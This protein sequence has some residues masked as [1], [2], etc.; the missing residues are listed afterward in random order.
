[1][2]KASAFLALG[3]S[4]L[5]SCSTSPTPTTTFAEAD[6]ADIVI[7]H[8]SDTVNRVLKP[9]QREGPFLSTFDNQGVLD[10]AKVQPHR[11]LAVVILPDFIAAEELKRDWMGLLEGV[12][13]QRVVF[14]SAHKGLKVNG[15]IVLE[16]PSAVTARQ[17]STFNPIS[18]GRH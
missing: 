14:L 12:G 13:Y 3:V 6:K 1:M 2:T 4:I 10:L 11:E 15:L 18:A 9:L 16:N 8:N 17:G 7:Q 5:T